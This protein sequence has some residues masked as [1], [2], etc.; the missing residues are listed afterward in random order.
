VTQ[1]TPVPANQTDTNSTGWV[2]TRPA[3][4]P[5]STIGVFSV[6][7]N[8]DGSPNVQAS[9]ANV[10]VPS[11]T[12]PANAPQSGTTFLLDT[13]DTRLTQAVSA[14]DPGHSNRVGIWT[15]H[16]V[17]GGAGA[18]VRWY[19]INPVSKVI[20]QT[21][22]V[23]ST[24]LYMFN[25]AI[26]PD[27]IVR[28][29]TRAFGNNMVLGFNTSSATTYPAIRMVSKRGADATSAIVTVRTAPGPDVDFSCSSTVACR[30]G[31]Y[32]AATPDPAASP[33]G[34]TGQ[35]WLTSMWNGDGR[36]SGTSTTAWRTW[37]WAAQ[38]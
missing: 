38:P 17:A 11:Y 36:V 23:K 4:L 6:T 33:S 22:T 32:A 10:T 8:V 31:D 9:G 35:V 13:S 14:I 1:F 28:G 21:G 37:N 34:A 27:R 29:A 20:M 16:T 5:A 30:W 19:E 3:S 2:L 25:G 24:S 15:Q 7:K 18:M 26:S 12:F